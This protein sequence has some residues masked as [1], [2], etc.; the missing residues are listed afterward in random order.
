MDISN[1]IF[2]THKCCSCGKPLKATKTKNLNMVELLRK[3]KWDYPVMGN[4][5]SGTSGRAVAII[6]DTC[7]ENEKP[8]KWALEYQGGMDNIKYHEV[9]SLEPIK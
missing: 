7:R 5:V 1:Q 9:T 2:K 6:C 3:A 4:V 8:I